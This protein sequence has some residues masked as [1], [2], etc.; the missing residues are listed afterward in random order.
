MI[1]PITMAL[2]LIAA[3]LAAA[4]PL[5]RTSTFVD[6]YGTEEFASTRFPELGFEFRDNDEFSQTKRSPSVPIAEEPDF[7]ELDASRPSFLL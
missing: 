1:R 5:P 6:V 2:P 3:C 4:S 7:E